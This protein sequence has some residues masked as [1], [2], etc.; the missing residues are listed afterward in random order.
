MLTGSELETRLKHIIETYPPT[1]LRSEVLKSNPP[2]LKANSADDPHF[3]KYRLLSTVYR[4]CAF[5]GWLELYRRDVTFLDTGQ[6][7]AN[8]ELQKGIDSFRNA[9]A[10]GRL[11]RAENWSE[12]RDALIF[13]EEQ[14]A[15]GELM[16][17][18]TTA[19]TIIGYGTFCTL[20]DRSTSD[21]N[22]WPLRTAGAFFLDLQPAL[23]F[24]P[25]RLRMMAGH[26]R[27]IVNVLRP[28]TSAADSV[29]YLTDINVGP[30]QSG[31]RHD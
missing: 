19:P 17:A 18:A 12:W 28:P 22:L 15:I 2:E 6:Q 5:L 16:I 13:R 14:R 21:Q 24:R 23:D 26:L 4:L 20:F 7:S 31:E 8:R 30:Q 29:E 27:Q 25:Q 3:K 1:F 11:N 10:E 9:L